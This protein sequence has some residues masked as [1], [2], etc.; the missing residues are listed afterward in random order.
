MPNS[1]GFLPVATVAPAKQAEDR[2]VRG[3]T[4][5]RSNRRQKH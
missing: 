1:S 3:T 2:N 4:V 5:G